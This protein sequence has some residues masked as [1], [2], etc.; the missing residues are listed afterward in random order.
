MKTW[1]NVNWSYC[2]HGCLCKAVYVI[3]FFKPK[4]ETIYFTNDHLWRLKFYVISRSTVSKNWKSSASRKAKE[5]QAAVNRERRR[6]RETE[7]QREKTNKILFNNLSFWYFCVASCINNA[8]FVWFSLIS[9][10]F[11]GFL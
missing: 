10:K 5:A 2:K 3:G 8:I 6:D 7:T 11:L 9:L 1:N 4:N